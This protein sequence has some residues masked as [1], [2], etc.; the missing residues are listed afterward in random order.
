MVTAKWVY[1]YFSR[2]PFSCVLVLGNTE[3]SVHRCLFIFFFS[4]CLHSKSLPY[5]SKLLHENTLYYCASITI[6]IIGVYTCIITC[7]YMTTC[8][9][10]YITMMIISIDYRRLTVL[11]ELSDIKIKMRYIPRIVRIICVQVNYCT[12]L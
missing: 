12:K 6:C 11:N 1:F 2:L 7:P 5:Q 9:L 8:I 4:V 10:Y 3:Y